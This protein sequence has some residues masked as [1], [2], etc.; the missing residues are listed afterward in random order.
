MSAITSQITGVSI[1][2]SAVCSGGDQRK[3]QTSASRALWSESTGK[4]WIS[5]TKNQWASNTENV[6]IW[7]RL[8]NG[9]WYM[10]PVLL[11]VIRV[12]LPGHHQ[13]ILRNGGGHVF[14]YTFRLAAKAYL[15][16]DIT[17]I[18]FSRVLNICQWLSVWYITFD[19]I[20]TF[21]GYFTCTET[22]KFVP[23][24][25]NQTW[26]TCYLKQKESRMLETINLNARMNV[27]LW[28]ESCQHCAHHI[29]ERS[30]SYKPI[31]RDP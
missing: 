16:N 20:H 28:Q 30:R 25:V 31:S 3:H 4:G 9:N 6:S 10:L 21:Y 29:S 26:T 1:I 23:R 14:W 24:P 13:N 17:W 11:Q 22:T 18:R 2:H 15:S 8:H 12:L 19:V 7:W 5:L 27:L